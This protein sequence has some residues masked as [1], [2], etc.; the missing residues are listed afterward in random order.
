MAMIVGERATIIVLPCSPISLPD[1]HARPLFGRIRCV[2]DD[3][4]VGFLQGGHDFIGHD[5]S[6]AKH[7]SGIFPETSGVSANFS[8]GPACG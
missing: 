3:S 1:P 4:L 7:A 2:K 6:V 5:R 8:M